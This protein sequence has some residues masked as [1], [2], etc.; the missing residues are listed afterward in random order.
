MWLPCDAYTPKKEIPPRN[1]GHLA[2][3]GGSPN[4]LHQRKSC[5][6]DN[7]KHSMPFRLNWKNK[8]NKHF[9]RAW[10]AL[11]LSLALSRDSTRDYNIFKKV[12]T[13]VS[14]FRVITSRYWHTSS[15]ELISLMVSESGSELS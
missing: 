10:R 1:I 4:T 15:F 12:R 8:L 9:H 7:N 13:S 5:R 3:L 11:C 6:K 14:W 2:F